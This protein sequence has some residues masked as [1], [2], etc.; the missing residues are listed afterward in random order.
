MMSPYERQEKILE[1]VKNKGL[2]KIE[3]LSE[4]FSDASQ[5][6]VRRDIK[7]LEKT[8]NIESLYGGIV[9]YL[10]NTDELPISKKVMINK[11]AKEE[12]ATV[13]A[14]QIN[15]G[16]NVYIDS[17][18]SAAVLFEKIVDKQITIY[19]TNT[20]IFSKSIENL[21][22][23]IIILGG[24]YNPLTSSLSG[25]FT[26]ESLKDIFFDKSFIGA[27][28]ADV[29]NGVTTPNVA[30][31]VKKRIVLEHS[32]QTY[33]LCDS[34]KF[35]LTSNVRAFNVEDVILISDKV[36]T[37]LSEITQFLTPDR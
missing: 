23:E 20:S 10:S 13:A 16:D 17:G 2:V 26:E 12:V 9:K 15:V 33:V 7:E 25:S 11:R 31:A 29:K 27:N 18:S 3:E 34:S 32:H 6:T 22:A 37:E 14:K 4:I 19:T 8:G 35:G 21:K 24:S 1:I 5:S 36:N 28:G 30:E